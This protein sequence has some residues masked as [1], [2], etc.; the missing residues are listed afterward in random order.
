MG[1]LLEKADQASR[2]HLLAAAHI[3]SQCW[4]H[5]LPTSTLG[6]LLALESLRIALRVWELMLLSH[7]CRCSRRMDARA[8]YGFSCKFS[9]TRHPNLQP[10]MI[11][12]NGVYRVREFLLFWNRWELTWEMVRAMMVLPCSYSPTG[13]V[14]T[15]LPPLPISMLRVSQYQELQLGRLKRE[16]PE[17][18]EHLRLVHGESMATLKAEIGRRT[19]DATGERRETLWL[20]PRLGLVVQRGNA[21]VILTTVPFNLNFIE[22]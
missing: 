3:E 22:V 1:R 7:M 12:L 18:T 16:G 19:T 11:K 6:T 13:E 21:L 15:G 8:L 17:R 5:T 10:Y 9:A 20:E 2:A 14:C 4:L